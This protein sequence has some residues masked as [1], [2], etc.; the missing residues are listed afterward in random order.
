MDEEGV[1]APSREG[2]P[3]SV[4]C[5]HTCPAEP[6]GNLPR[7]IS[8]LPVVEALAVAEECG[9]ISG[10]RRMYVQPGLGFHGLRVSLP[11]SPATAV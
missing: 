2:H 3:T 8:E 5:F 9:A 7:L 11:E 6:G 4:A 10:V 1:V